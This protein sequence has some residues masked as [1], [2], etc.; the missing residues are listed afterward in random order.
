QI[1]H[2]RQV[3]VSPMPY[4]NGSFRLPSWLAGA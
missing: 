3:I 1:Q 2:G 4:S